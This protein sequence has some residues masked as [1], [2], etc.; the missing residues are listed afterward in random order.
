MRT[1]RFSDAEQRLLVEVLERAYAHL[2]EEFVHTDDRQYRESPEAREGQVTALL[3]K[4]K[5]SESDR[6]V[7]AP[8]A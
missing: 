2:I 3:Q 8:R 4:L 1:I 6:H 7:T 5:T